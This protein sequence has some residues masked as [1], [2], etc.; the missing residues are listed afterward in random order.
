MAPFYRGYI[1]NLMLSPD[2]V[3][4]IQVKC[5]QTLF[6]Y[7]VLGTNIYLAKLKIFLILSNMSYTNLHG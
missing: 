5:I 6:W 3:R 1:P 2:D 7:R 4:G